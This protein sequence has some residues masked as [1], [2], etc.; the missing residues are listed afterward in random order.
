M[1]GSLPMPKCDFCSVDPWILMGNVSDANLAKIA[2]KVDEK[3]TAGT[4]KHGG[5]RWWPPVQLDDFCLP[6][7]KVSGCN[8]QQ[9]E[10]LGL[11][12]F[13]L[14]ETSRHGSKRGHWG[15]GIIENFGTHHWHGRTGDTN[16]EQFGEYG[17]VVFRYVFKLYLNHF[18]TLQTPHS[19]EASLLENV[20]CLWSSKMCGASSGICLIGV[21]GRGL[22]LSDESMMSTGMLEHHWGWGS[23]IFFSGQFAKMF[24]GFTQQAVYCGVFCFE[25]LMGPIVKIVWDLWINH[26]KI[27]GI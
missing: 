13:D 2:W 8:G 14:F 21:F 26:F 6:A 17:I 15:H 16:W 22:V 18:C 12:K 7:E 23:K 25:L 19:G 20:V 10:F 4:P 11:G 5:E 3:L 27:H 1:L 24:L 9:K